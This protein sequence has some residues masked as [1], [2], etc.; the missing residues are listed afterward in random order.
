[1]EIF[2]DIRNLLLDMKKN[3]WIEFFIFK[4]IHVHASTF[5]KFWLRILEFIGGND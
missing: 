3:H 1:M 5:I 2:Q 4:K